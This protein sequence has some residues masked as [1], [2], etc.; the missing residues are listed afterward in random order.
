MVVEA[1]IVAGYV[2]AWAVRKARRAGGRL[3]QT[4]DEAIEV[5]ANRLHDA[6]LTR[7][8][9]HP[10][11]VDLAEEAGGEAGSVSELTR[12]QV[13]LAI[14][15]AAR[16]DEGFAATVS[17]LLARVRTAEQASGGSV[18]DGVT[19]FYGDAT[20]TARDGGIAIGQARAVTVNGPER[21]TRDPH[22]PGRDSH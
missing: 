5:A 11:L 2:I 9:G 20:V 16:R 15:A 3:D 12:Q 22:G 19:N 8:G 7:L 21:S 1:G 4:V 14:T 17:D 6:V 13:E 18:L 10:V